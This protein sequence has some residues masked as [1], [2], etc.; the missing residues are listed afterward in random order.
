MDTILVSAALAIFLCALAALL[1]H[2]IKT[3]TY[4]G[5]TAI[6]NGMCTLSNALDGERGAASLSAGCTALCAYLWWRDGGGDGTRRRLRSLRRKFS[7][8]RRTAPQP[9]A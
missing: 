3:K 8:V 4:N 9:T 7:G 5:A 1:T 2:R 6:A